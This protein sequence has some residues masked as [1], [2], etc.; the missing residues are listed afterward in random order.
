M[1]YF[2]ELF[3]KY[4]TYN[5]GLLQSDVSW[6]LVYEVIYVCWPLCMQDDEEAGILEKVK[7][8]ICEIIELYT[9]RYE[10][11]FKQLPTFFTTVLQLLIST[12]QEPKYDV[13]CF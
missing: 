5:N 13:V 11:E 10:E 2:M 12:P 1:G 3:H 6:M 4:L 8:G 9:Q 7:A